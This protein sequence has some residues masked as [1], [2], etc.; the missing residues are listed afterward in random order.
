[1]LL[2]GAALAED[3]AAAKARGEAIHRLLETLH[4]RPAADWPR[5]AERI[6]AGHEGAE[7]LLA[8]AVAVLGA[9]E[10]AALFGPGSRAEV[11]LTAALPALGGARIL[12]R[13]DRLVVAP[14]RV[15]AVDF[16]SNRAVPDRPEAVPEG[17][18]R[19]MGAYAAALAAIWPARAVETAIVWTRVP[20]LM[21]LPGPLVAAALAR[22]GHLDPPG[23]R[24]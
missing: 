20:R 19:Q 6:L 13:V 14:D 4:A 21:P 22:A 24:P 12:G 7:A 15:L 10:L 18:L 16:K 3:E 11:E 2:A 23:A 8:E 9:P 5:L 17:I 1:M